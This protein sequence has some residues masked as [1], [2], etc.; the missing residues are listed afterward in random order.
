MSVDDRPTLSAP[1]DD[2]WLWLEEIEGKQA[3]DFV[4]RQNQLTLAAFGGAAFERDR[5]VLAAIYD[6]PDN[7]PYVS[8]RGDDLHNLWK[9]AVNPR[10]LWRRTTL[11]EFRKPHP[12]WEIMLDID[13]LAAHEGEDWLL[14][15][16]AT[17]PGR[18][19]AILSLSRGGSDAVTLRE[20]DIDTKSFVADG[21]TLPEAKGGVDWIDAD[22]LLLSSA[23]GEGM[24][25]T[26]G[27]SRTVRVW[28]RGQPVDQAQT[29]LE[30][31]ADHMAMSGMADDTGPAPRVWIVDQIDFF[32]H[33]IW[34]RDAAG[35]TTKL[36]L[37]TGIWMQ[38]HGDWFA[39]KLRKDWQVEGRTYATDT[40]LGISLSA[41]LAGH[42]DFAVLFEPA[43]RRALQGLFWAGGRLVLSILDELRPRF[44]ICTPSAKGWS[45]ETLPGLPEIGVVDIWPL[46]RHPSESNG[47]LLANVQD[48]LTPPSLLLLERGAASPTVLKQ[49]P[50]T[51][52]ADGLVVT[53]H[54]A[55]SIDGERIPYVQTGPAGE[56]GDAPV[57]MSAYGGFGHAVKPYYN[58]SLGKLWLE[59]GGTI[60]Q[61]NLRGGGEFGTRWHDAGRLAGKKLSHDDFAA[62]AADLVRRGVTQ[63]KRI[64][65]QGGS[66]GGILITNM[67]VRYP[68][69]FGALFCTIPLIDMR[70]YTK[71]LAGASW[72]AE[73]GDP[74][75]PEEW[76]WLQTYSAYHNV[77]ASQSYPPI[78]IATTR[79]DDRVHPGHAR[80]MAAKLQAMG[81]EAWFYEPEA[82]GHGYG[83]DN[84]ERAGFEVI[85]FR[86][87]KD[88]IGWKDG[89]A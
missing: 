79:R 12:A 67:L 52:T 83:K 28:R 24:A 60:V 85:G 61:A 81:Y 88:R 45:R 46:D 75:K 23:H 11:A 73:Y 80:K 82:G 38:A 56:T 44:E 6:R 72:I 29:I 22:T 14:S 30:T 34:L 9:D 53:Q 89:E 41:F 39:M 42:R 26:S 62:I 43:P 3:L 40:V 76:E 27:Y 54:E 70:R 33:A 8:R 57:Y 1:D 86:F 5:D 65:A 15:G 10:G 2:P 50:K 36:D 16:I 71:L 63:P 25:T 58:P 13:Q 64:A 37:P 51:F 68:E 78:L 19:R 31:T 17:M 21:F 20:F 7:I 49:A 4:A 18:S 66:N 55:I 32:N 77:K 59:R 69:R 84:K 47:D 74:D 35:A 87:L 48:P